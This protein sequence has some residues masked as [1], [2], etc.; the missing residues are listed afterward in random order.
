MYT[1]VWLGVYA[2]VCGVVLV[3][4]LIF[5]FVRF[6]FDHSR[7]DM[8]GNFATRLGP[9]AGARVLFV[10]SQLVRDPPAL[11]PAHNT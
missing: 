6:P 11:T 2:C 8:R 4:V 9:P 3:L 7:L 1:R 10:L 5:L